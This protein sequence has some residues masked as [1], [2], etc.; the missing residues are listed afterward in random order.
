[1][2]QFTRK[3]RAQSCALI[4]EAS[5]MKKDIWQRAEETLAMMLLAVGMATA[6]AILAVLQRLGV[7]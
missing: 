4:W 5:N 1:M 6:A 2:L 7:L 3:C